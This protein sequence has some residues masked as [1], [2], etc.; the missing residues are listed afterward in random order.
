M[1]NLEVFAE[2][3]HWEH[4]RQRRLI[5]FVIVLE[6]ILGWEFDN[7]ANYD[8]RP[9]LFLSI[10]KRIVCSFFIFVNIPAFSNILKGVCI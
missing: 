6:F 8:I 7:N 1:S 3:G 9:H 10:A 5:V 2:C 4:R